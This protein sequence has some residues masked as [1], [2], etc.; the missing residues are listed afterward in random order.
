MAPGGVVD[1]H[2][3]MN[4]LALSVVARTL[5]VTDDAEKTAAE[6]HRPAPVIFDGM[7]IALG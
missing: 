2:K 7:A 4:S 5:C 1:V 6:L 3:E